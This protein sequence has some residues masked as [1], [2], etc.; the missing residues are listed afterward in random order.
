MLNI[1]STC[2][3]ITSS[4]C[5]VYNT[6]IDLSIFLNIFYIIGGLIL[7]LSIFIIGREIYFRF[8]Y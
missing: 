1:T 2:E 8:R 3:V 5:Q 7:F 6:Q 4:V